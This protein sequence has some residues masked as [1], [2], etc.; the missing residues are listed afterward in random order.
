MRGAVF[1]L[2]RITVVLVVGVAALS[3]CGASTKT[4][5]AV[6]LR[7]TTTS[8]SGIALTASVPASVVTKAA[9]SV[10]Q[11][12]CDNAGQFEFLGS[13]FVTSAGLITSAHVIGPCVR[14]AIGTVGVRL[15]GLPGYAKTFDTIV[16]HND[17]RHDVA[18][19]Q[20]AGAGASL[21][22]GPERRPARVGE[23]VVLLGFSGGGAA[24]PIP[25]HG[26]V[27]QT[28]RPATVTSP[29]GVHETLSDAIT[30]TATGVIPGDSGGPAI[31]AA[32][33]I[34]GVIEASNGRSAIL[35]PA[36]DYLALP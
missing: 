8:T 14:G 29:E 35:S 12:E 22:L 23:Q 17:T 4:V 5:T 20:L 26:V 24:A 15:P 25:I 32:G 31:D 19:L 9:R 27:A 30:V 2:A 21:A 11:V 28:G 16:S 36:A 13:G 6:H 18:L 1:G 33:N 34:V 7:S 10:A 3:G